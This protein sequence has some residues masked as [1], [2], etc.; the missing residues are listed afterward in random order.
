MIVVKLSGGLGNQMFQYVF[1]QYISKK[2]NSKVEYNIDFYDD[3]D[4]R[5]DFRNYELNKFNMDI[6]IAKNSSLSIYNR[7]TK[8][9]KIFFLI[10]NFLFNTKDSFFVIVESRYKLLS[11]FSLLFANKYFVGY[12]QDKYFLESFDKEISKWFTL[13]HQY[14]EKKVQN[15]AHNKNSVSIGVRR[16]DYVDLNA[17]CDIDYYRRA[18][19][20]ISQNVEQPFFL[21]FSDDIVWCKENLDLKSYCHKYIEPNI[22]VPF[23]DMELISK[24]KHNIISNSTYGWWGAYLNKN[25]NKIILS[26]KGWGLSKQIDCVEL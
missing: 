3:Q 21:I 19:K 5:L 18:I 17:T 16:G 26:P 20:F 11:F 8:L 25:K 12:W 7:K 2:Y 23:A 10:S 22:D 1:G 24:C 6:P 15:L 4:D 14:P 9:E 13:K